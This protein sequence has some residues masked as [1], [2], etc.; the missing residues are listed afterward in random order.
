MFRYSY[1]YHVYVEILIVYFSA[2]AMVTYAVLKPRPVGRT[3]F[4]GI[5]HA[6]GGD[7]TS[8]EKDEANF[9]ESGG[10]DSGPD[11]EKEEARKQA[12]K[13]MGELSMQEVEPV[14]RAIDYA[15]IGLPDFAAFIC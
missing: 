1:N 13:P 2:N 5:M 6:I 12:K 9:E 15:T 11:N 4:E 14:V 8:F 3:F 7:A 10:D